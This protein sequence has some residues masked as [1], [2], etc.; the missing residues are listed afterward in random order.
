MTQKLVT[1]FGGSGF[2]GRHLVRRL[3]PAGHRIRI[4]ARDAE[5]AKFLMTAGVPGQIVSMAGDIT[6]RDDVTRAVEGADWVVNLVGLL[7]PW[8][9][10]M[11]RAVHAEGARKVAEAAST[12]GAEA[13][14]QVS[15]IGADPNARSI[16]ARTKA[17]GELA[18]R[19][20]FPKATILRPSV[21]FGQEDDFFNRFGAMA[22]MLPVLPVFG[23]PT[24]PKIK[25]FGDNDVVEIDLYGDGGTKFQPVFVGDVAEAIQRC[26]ADP[27]RAGK[28]YELGGPR[29]YSFKALME[30][31]MAQSGHKRLLLPYPF[32]LAKAQAAL[33]E[34]IPNPPLTVDQ[35]IQLQSDNVVADDALT[36]A[37]LGIQPT[38]AEAILPSYLRAY[39]DPATQKRTV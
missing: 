15:A 30:L 6:N 10:Q 16:Y 5:A 28:T 2:I 17:E 25:L 14:V 7:A 35:V 9:R 11:F 21:L 33:M 8:G 24:W 4:V 22:R 38:L 27:D 13:M 20:A 29:V 34:M 12:A 23:C 19:A 18:V 32:W 31:V 39:R 37:D 26:L 36:L 3:A 1:I